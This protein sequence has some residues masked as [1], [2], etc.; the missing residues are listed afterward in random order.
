MVLVLGSRF[1]KNLG[2]KQ[3]CLEATES[4]ILS[5]LENLQVV[6]EAEKHVLVR[7]LEDWLMFEAD[8][9]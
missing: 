6:R 7:L 8:C 2:P 4:R 3:I 1:E 9:I 5:L